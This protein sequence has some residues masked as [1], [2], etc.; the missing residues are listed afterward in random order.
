MI[1]DYN[2]PNDPG[3][4]NG[5][6]RDSQESSDEQENS[7]TIILDTTCAPQNISYPQDVNLLNEAREKAPPIKNNLQFY[8]HQGTI[9]FL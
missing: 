3:P 2:S 9:T 4:G 6:G 1:I 7:G 5:G 8:N